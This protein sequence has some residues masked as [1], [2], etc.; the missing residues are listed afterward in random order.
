MKIKSVLLGSVALA[1]AL[2]AQNLIQRSQMDPKPS[3]RKCPD[4]LQF[5]I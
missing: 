3:S 4:G 5:G 1:T 2:N